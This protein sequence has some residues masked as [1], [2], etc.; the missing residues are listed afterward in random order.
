M[1]NTVRGRLL[2]T[3][4]A[5]LSLLVIASVVAVASARQ[6]RSSMVQV[7]TSDDALE[8]SIVQRFTLMDDQETGLRGYL[9]TRDTRFLQP[10]YNAVRLLP[11]LEKQTVTLT[12][13]NAQLSNLAKELTARATTWQTWAKMALATPFT[14]VPSN[15]V[16]QQLEGRRRFDAYRTQSEKILRIVSA[17]R[18]RHLADSNSIASMLTGLLT[19]IFIVAVALSVV[20]TWIMTR[21]VTQPLVRLAATAGMIGRGDLNEKVDVQAAE[22]F[23][24]LGSSMEQMR[25]RLIAD[26][27]ALQDL[28]ATLERRIQERTRQLELSNEE[29]QS[30]A[31]SVSHDL[32]APL[33]SIDGFSQAMLEDFGESLPTEAQ[34]YL[35]RVRANA[36]RMGQLIDGLLRLSR[37]TRSSLERDTV[38]LSKM[39]RDILETL[40]ESSPDRKVKTVIRDGVRAQADPRLLLPALDNLLSNA[41]KFTARNPEACIEF[42]VQGPEDNIYFVRDNGAGFDMTYADKLFGAFQRLHGADEFEGTGIGLATV[43]RIIYRHGGEIWAESKVGRGATFFFTLQPGAISARQQTAVS[44]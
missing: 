28:N 37:I 14:A 3:Y 39:A 33:R 34:D 29:L 18:S 27:T 15:I 31:Y 2:L 9:L 16:G 7:V 17:D 40:Q 36:Q 11:N 8:N 30:F 12:R 13:G 41:W 10:Y 42:G 43:Q 19:M 35:A 32:R 23:R 21:S 4:L 38:D 25:Q 5:I 22:E 20:I 24:Q 44:A 1:P 26:R 6:L